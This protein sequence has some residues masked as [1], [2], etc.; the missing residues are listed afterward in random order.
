MNK[1]LPL[2]KD[3]SFNGI[4]EL[5]IL[6]K[7][8]Q[9]IISTLDFQEVLQIISNGMSEL[10]DIES[11][12]IYLLENEKDL[13]LGATTPALDPNMPFAL[14]KAVLNEHPHIEKAILSREPV[15]VTDTKEAKLSQKERDVVDM[16]SLRSLLYLPFVQ[17]S[18][19][20]G[21]LILG[22][23]NKIRP[24]SDQEVELGQ[25]VANQLSIAIQNSKFHSDLENYKDN[26]ERLVAERTNDLETLNEELKSMNEEL[27]LKNE[28]VSRQ[29][30]E[31]QI[32]L[33]ELQ[34]AQV[35]LIQSEKMASL[36]VLTSGVAH[37]IN[38]PLN[39]IMGAHHGLE[40]F[41]N[42]KAPE[43]KESVSVL[44]EGLKAGVDRASKIVQGLNLF[45]RDN[46]AYNEQC[47]INLIIDNCLVMLQNQYK[48]NIQIEKSYEDGELVVPGN[49]GK[50]HQAFL[51]ILVNSIQAIEDSGI[52]KIVTRKDGDAAFISIQDNG[53]GIPS[54]NLSK[55]TDPFFTTKEPQRGTGLGLSIT[56]G[57]IRDH[58]GQ[59][60][61]ESKLNS[62]TTARIV[63]PGKFQL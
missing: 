30:E 51:N 38:N 28:L 32:S 22:T 13:L 20:L 53:C 6:I 39:F 56:Y 27:N 21:V 1:V 44:L 24:F 16:R 31:L 26:L 18:K 10:L 63:L 35:K 19:V 48:N 7:V 34:A 60:D 54:E 43:H 37:E 47:S 61:F 29:K 5:S 2:L 52:I 57:V 9:S 12:A 11:A 40:V 45:S 49:V 36:G 4:R 42:T 46:T 33:N 3:D 17:K 25:T 41:F 14:R 59:L 55:I 23:C 62:G 58:G 50:L 15:I 8:S